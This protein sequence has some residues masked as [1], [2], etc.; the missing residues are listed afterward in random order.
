M[1]MD[2]GNIDSELIRML[3]AKGLEVG[4]N[5]AG[6]LKRINFKKL[7]SVHDHEEHFLRMTFLQL[8][9][10]AHVARE[11]DRP[12]KT[13]I[14]ATDVRTAMMKLGK[15]AANAPDHQFSENS[16]R[17]LRDSCPYCME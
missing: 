13:K 14:T 3:A 7:V 1:Y 9:K 6:P 17:K 12:T 11:I 10:E 15:A 8:L 2:K 16:K 5:A 4:M